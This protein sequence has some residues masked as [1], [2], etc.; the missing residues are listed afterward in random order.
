[1][2][3]CLGSPL[4]VYPRR[5]GFNPIGWVLP[6]RRLAFFDE[7]EAAD[8]RCKHETSHLRQQTFG[9]EKLAGYRLYGLDGV[10][11]VASGEWI[12]ADDD[13]QAIEAAKYRFDGS[14]CEIWQGSRLVA[15]IEGHERR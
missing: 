8:Q 13:D 4:G 15:R 9:F 10:D 5:Q 11:K 1:M 7:T 2:T 12:D 14:P 3:A 6:C